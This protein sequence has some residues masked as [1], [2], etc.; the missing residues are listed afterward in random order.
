[1]NFSK[2]NADEMKR[3]FNELNLTTEIHKALHRVTQSKELIFYRSHQ[4]DL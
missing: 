4:N 2:K 1:M 3:R